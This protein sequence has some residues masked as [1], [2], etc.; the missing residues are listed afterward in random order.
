MF[1]R[2][3][4]N[5]LNSLSK[6]FAFPANARFK[7]V[8]H[9]SGV[10]C[11]SMFESI[12]FDAY[13]QNISKASNNAC[14]FGGVERLAVVGDDAGG[15]RQ[16]ISCFQHTVVVL[17]AVPEAHVDLAVQQRGDILRSHS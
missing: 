12:A 14:A 7:P 16:G 15:Q 9:S 8:R 17:I 11:P 10:I 5:G 2:A 13:C 6:T 3:C 4:A 1:H